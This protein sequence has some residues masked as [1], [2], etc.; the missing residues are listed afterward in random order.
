MLLVVAMFAG[1]EGPAESPAAPGTGDLIDDDVSEHLRALGYV[2]WDEDADQN[3]S[4]A[5]LHDPSAIEPGAN[6]YTND[7]DTVFLIDS[8]GTLLRSWELPGQPRASPTSP[9]SCS[10]VRRPG[11]G[12]ADE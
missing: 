7:E 3:L 11:P 2:A 6:L 1:C 10:C 8:E 12:A 5:I 9:T 4:G